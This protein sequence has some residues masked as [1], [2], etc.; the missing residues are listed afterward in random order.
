M[1]KEEHKVSIQ[2]RVDSS[3]TV[4]CVWLFS[5]HMQK[6]EANSGQLEGTQCTPKQINLLPT[7]SSASV[8]LSCEKVFKNV[9]EKGSEPQIALDGCSIGVPS[10]WFSDG[11]HRVEKLTCHQCVSVRAN[12]WQLTCIVEVLRVVQ[13]P[14]KCYINAVI[15]RFT[16]WQ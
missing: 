5:F 8:T 11:W 9:F 2:K 3:L 15:Y 7:P 13:K 6:T 12:G 4:H 16:F 14:E 1:W 10:A